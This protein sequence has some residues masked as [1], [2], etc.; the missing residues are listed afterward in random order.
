MFV[1]DGREGLVPGDEEI[2]A[3]LRDGR[4]A[5]ASWPSTR[6]TTS[7]RAGGAVEFYQLGFEPVVEIAAEHGDGRRRPARRDRVDARLPETARTRPQSLRTPPQET[8]I[9]IVGRPNVGKSSLVNRLLREERVDRQRDA[10]HDARRR[11]RAC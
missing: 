3:E 8:A 2:A 10:G 11:R 4:C 5:G 6:P 9:A 7:G 1:V